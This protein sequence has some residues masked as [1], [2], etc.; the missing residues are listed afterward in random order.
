MRQIFI[1][2]IAAAVAALCTSLPASAEEETIDYVPESIFV[3]G[4]LTDVGSSALIGKDKILPFPFVY[5][6]NKHVTL[7][8]TNLYIHPVDTGPVEISAMGAMRVST[9]EM[10]SDDR[11]KDFDRNIA[12]EVGGRA[13]FRFSDFSLYGQYLTDVTDAHGGEEITIGLTWEKQMGQMHLSLN[14][15]ARHRSAELAT[16]L[17]GVTANDSASGFNVHTL[18]ADW[19]PFAEVRASYPISGRWGLVLT[20]AGERLPEKALLSPIVE[21][22]TTLKAGAGITYT[23]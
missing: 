1:I 5:Y 16:Y 17:Y 4:A 9:I 20:G 22:R 18:E 15:G 6:H 3:V 12:F 23:F 2:L 11:L 21:K 13:S 8:T 7:E 19:Y 10:S 14:G